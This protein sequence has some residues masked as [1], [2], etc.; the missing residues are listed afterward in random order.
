MGFITQLGRAL[1]LIAALAAMSIGT[2]AA[3]TGTFADGRDGKKYKT[4]KIG[5]RTWMAEN[6]NYKTEG[7]SWCYDDNNSN[8]NK[9]GR[10][11]DWNMAK[12]ACPKG[13][14]LPSKS[15]WREL[16]VVAD[17]KTSGIKLKS[18]S[19]WDEKG[20]GTDDLGFSALP[21]GRRINDG[22]FR[23]VDKRG[24]WW[25]ATGH[26]SAF[27]FYRYMYHVKDYADEDFTFRG[28]GFSVRCL[29]D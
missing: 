8:C 11:Y 2:A 1:L 5:E 23:N 4:V 13:W 3:Q 10:L 25:T 26:G 20:N 24:Y 6:L 7:G 16:V 15:D 22:R 14:H 21:G 27:A 12:T 9:Y 17:S 29:Q 19:G 18:K 28:D